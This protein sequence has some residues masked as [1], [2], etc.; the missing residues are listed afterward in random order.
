MMTDCLMM[1]LIGW[2]WFCWWWLLDDVD[3]WLIMV[4]IDDVDDDNDSLM[5]MLLIDILWRWWWFM[6]SSL[7]STLHKAAWL[8]SCKSE[9]QSTPMITARESDARF[10]NRL[11]WNTVHKSDFVLHLNFARRSKII[12]TR[13][14]EAQ[15]MI[16]MWRDCQ[17]NPDK[18][19]TQFVRYPASPMYAV[20]SLFHLLC[21]PQY[22]RL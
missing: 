22:C 20:Y 5:M 15:I 18:W 6:F 3:D 13:V 17:Q 4:M 8:I 12:Q 7:P 1:M 10:N 11:W 16:E 14:L 2:C 21:R 19:P 9:F